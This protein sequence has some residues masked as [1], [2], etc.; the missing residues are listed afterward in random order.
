VV[1]RRG[2]SGAIVAAICVV[3]TCA[4]CATATP[5]DVARPSIATPPPAVSALAPARD[6]GPR[7]LPEPDVR[8]RFAPQLDVEITVSRSGGV[9]ARTAAGASCTAS[10]MLAGGS[11]VMTMPLR[12]ADP[13]GRVAW[14][15]ETAG[16]GGGTHTVSCTRGGQQVTSGASFGA[17]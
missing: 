17:P 12:V 9:E 1:H 7:P 3:A 15:Y 10:V 6:R 14:T 11:S 4:S 16:A 2:P 13:D 8:G 5:P